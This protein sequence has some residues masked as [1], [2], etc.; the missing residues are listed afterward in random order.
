MLSIYNSEMFSI[1]LSFFFAVLLIIDNILY[2]A[3][4]EIERREFDSEKKT[5]LN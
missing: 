1:N 2:Y 4:N 3:R 5:N